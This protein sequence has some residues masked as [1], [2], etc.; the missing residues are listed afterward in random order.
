MNKDIN[1]TSKTNYENE[2]KEKKQK[3]FDDFIVEEEEKDNNDNEKF[4]NQINIEN[5]AKNK[6]ELVKDIIYKDR[7]T[8]EFTPEYNKK[9][10][11]II[12]KM[13]SGKKEKIETFNDKNIIS[14]YSGIYEISILNNI[15]NFPF[16]YLYRNKKT[17]DTKIF[18]KDDNKAKIFNY[19]DENEIKGDAYEKEINSMIDVEKF[20][21][22]NLI[23]SCFIVYQEF[24][25]ETKLK[26]DK[27]YEYNN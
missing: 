9:I 17:K 15:I 3:F 22:D 14:G 5:E 27:A 16:Y 6:E 13:Y 10:K 7:H 26:R 12:L 23:M 1:I 4:E 19:M 18:I 25:R 20:S 11:N 21:E 8:K 24:K 2:I